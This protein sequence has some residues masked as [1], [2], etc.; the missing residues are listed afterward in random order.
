MRTSSHQ[1]KLA[2]LASTLCCCAFLGAAENGVLASYRGGSVTTTEVAGWRAFQ[3]FGESKP[4]TE[5][6]IRAVALLEIYEAEASA[7]GLLETPSGALLYEAQ[8]LELALRQLAADQNAA[9]EPTEEALMLYW[10]ENEATFVRPRRWRLENIF[11]ARDQTTA[12]GNAD[13]QGQLEALREQVLSGSDFGDL[14]SRYSQSATR[15]RRGA[16]GWVDEDRLLPEAAAAVRQLEIGEISPVVE[17]A[18]GWT[19]LRLVEA[20]PPTTLDFEQVRPRLRSR[21]KRE[22]LEAL[23]RE[24]DERLWRRTG[25][26]EIAGPPLAD[27]DTAVSYLGSAERSH[28]SVARVSAFAE[29]RDGL[30]AAEIG[31]EDWKQL[32]RDLVL[33]QARAM[34]A[35]RRGLL[36]SESF[37]DDLLWLRRH[38]LAS[39][40][41]EDK[42]ARELAPASDS[43]LATLFNEDPSAYSTAAASHIRML[44]VRL[45]SET[46]ADLVARAES[47]GQRL[48]TLSLEE[49]AEAM[50]P[51]GEFVRVRDLGWLDE[52]DHFHL[53]FRLQPLA[54]GLAVGERTPLIQQG[55]YLL[56]VEKTAHRPAF[57]PTLDEARAQ[58]EAAFRAQ[59]IREARVALENELLEE[60][61]F[62]LESPDAP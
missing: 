61:E 19:L 60:H 32:C 54:L 43:E 9:A 11:L 26:V 16:M 35:E 21:I 45:G 57:Q 59:R 29:R 44:E 52:Q 47:V 49:A 4:L 58:V 5:R 7:R 37:S 10:Q 27:D 2:A 1:R 38:L 51:D 25:P 48:G 23:E 20:T 14:A 33:A 22:R 46:P 31:S 41:V 50:D 40:W 62:R 17:S 6:Q 13:P 8:R 28:L 15:D 24:L 30:A 42:V 3:R 34:E 55:P 56:T 12:E 36:D 39:L 53:G 18:R